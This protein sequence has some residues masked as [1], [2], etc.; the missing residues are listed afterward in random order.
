MI[1]LFCTGF[2][3]F[4]KSKDSLTAGLENIPSRFNGL[5]N[6]YDTDRMFASI[7][8]LSSTCRLKKGN[9]PAITKVHENSGTTPSQK[10]KIKTELLSDSIEAENPA[11]D[12]VANFPSKFFT[13]V[14]E[15]ISALQRCLDKQS[16]NYINKLLKKEGRLKKGISKLDSNAAKNVFSINANDRYNSLLRQL[17]TDSTDAVRKNFSGEYYPYI[18]SLQTALIYM[19]KNPQLMAGSDVTPE[20]IGS[21]LKNLMVLQS[22]MQDA[23]QIKQYIQQRKEQLKGYLSQ[24]TKLPHSISK[25]YQNYNKQFYYYSE[26]VKEFKET[27]NDPAKATK[28]ALTILNKV[29]AFSNFM[30]K[31]SLL[32]SIFNLTGTYSPSAPG[33]GLSTRDQ[34]LASLQNRITTTGGPNPSSFVQQKIQSAQ[35]VVDQ[36]RDKFKSYSNNSTE[37]IDIPNFHPNDQKTKSFLKRLQL[38]TDLQT[39]HGNYYFPTTTDFALSLGYKMNSKNDIGIGASIKM[40]WGKDFD[41][42]KVT[43]QGAGVRS[44]IDI[45]IKKSF[46]GTGGFEYNYQQPFDRLALPQFKEWQQSGLLG[47]TKKISLGTKFLKSMK[48]QLLWDFL[49]YQQ[50]PRG[51]VLK[52]RFGYNF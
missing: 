35:G 22:R 31:N 38:G 36:V 11:L 49:S 47:I 20:K 6:T 17:K 30:K 12:K 42:I 16:Q 39:V 44:F 15:K 23:D 8:K 9:L 4:G 52:F 19:N 25:A 24:F 2:T 10:I 33:Q 5:T 34:V 46:Y 14:N 21:T 40:G 50:V 1:L 48:T 45:N 18:D 29:P 7:Q 32:A 41:H 3:C 26:Q 37:D 28:L 13:K 43:G 51:Q 27:L